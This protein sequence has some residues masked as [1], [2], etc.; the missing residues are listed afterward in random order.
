MLTQTQKDKFNGWWNNQNTGRPLVNLRVRKDMQ[1]GQNVEYNNPEEMY[2]DVDKNVYNF[3]NYLKNNVFLCEAFPS[4]D[5]N[6]GAGSFALYLGSEPNFTKETVWFKEIATDGLEALAKLEFDS[7]NVWFKRHMEM[8]SHA[9]SISEGLFDVTIPDIIENMD[10]LASLRGAQDLCY[11]LYDYP[12]LVEQKLKEL[13][14]IYMN[15]YNAFY[16]IAKLDDDSSIYTAFCI[17][18]AGKSAKLQCDFNALMSPQQFND[19]VIPS[20]TRQCNAMD[21]AMFHLDGKEAAIHVDALVGIEKL[22]AIQWT[23]GD[24]NPDCFDEKWY[25]MIYDKVTKAK[26]SLHLH[27]GTPEANYIIRGI[28]KLVDRYGTNG[29]FFNLPSL[30]ER[31]AD[32]LLNYFAKTY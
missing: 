12:E 13:D 18:G 31:E 23:H 1:I 29:L 7:N 21:N 28:D 6:L 20:L 8:I 25:E 3:K 17:W 19:L 11:D 14:D 26:K 16:D 2:C 32:K 15:Y 10:V 30:N 22:K 5:L 4:I 27:M 9:K 24:G